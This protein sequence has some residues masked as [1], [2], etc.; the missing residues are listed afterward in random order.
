[1]IFCSFIEESENKWTAWDDYHPTSP[2]GTGKTESEAVNDL[3]QQ[4][5]EEG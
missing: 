1:M 5:A 2:I 4:I 3:F